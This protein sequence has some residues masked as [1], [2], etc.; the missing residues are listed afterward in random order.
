[1]SASRKGLPARGNRLAASRAMN[2]ATLP[3]RKWR[4]SRKRHV[5]ARVASEPQRYSALQDI[6]PL[7]GVAWR[8]WMISVVIPAAVMAH[9]FTG[10]GEASAAATH[11][12]AGNE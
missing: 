6:F 12:V 10:R 4:D 9:L 1:M 2:V 7:N 3:G 5:A 11:D 8:N